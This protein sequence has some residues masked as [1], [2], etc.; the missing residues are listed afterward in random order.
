MTKLLTLFLAT[1]LIGG[2][3]FTPP[4]RLR[5]ERER[6]AEEMQSLQAS[7]Y[8]VEHQLDKAKSE[9][10]T[11][12]LDLEAE[13]A[14][15]TDARNALAYVRWCQA[16][17]SMLNLCNDE[18]YN[19]GLVAYENGERVDEM[20][21]LGLWGWTLLEMTGVVCLAITTPLT[22]WLSARKK[23]VLQ[24]R[25]EMEYEEQRLQALR[26]Q[27]DQRE[28]EKHD[29]E[30]Q[31]EDLREVK[32]DSL[33]QLRELHDE[34]QTSLDELEQIKRLRSMLDV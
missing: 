26:D 24:T 1:A 32:D 10:E 33:D 25:E 29:L 22:L 28:Q 27:C 5:A 12:R 16:I 3:I 4:D 21:L 13:R 31:L 18:L 8:K 6:H 19:D 11:C 2:C 15:R 7:K 34:I 30:R 23:R 9:L 14:H 17:G 20:R